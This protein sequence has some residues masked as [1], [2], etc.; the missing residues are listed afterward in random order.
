MPRPQPA[1]AV[2]RMRRITNAEAARRCGYTQTWVSLVLNGHR[3]G[4]AE[5][6]R[7]LAIYLDLPEASLFHDDPPERGAA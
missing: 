1:L 4:S 5:F 7:K 2:L 6:R 3:R